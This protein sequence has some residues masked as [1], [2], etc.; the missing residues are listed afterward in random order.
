MTRTRTTRGTLLALASI[1]FAVLTA[2]GQVVPGQSGY[3]IE[4]G[5]P[6]DLHGV[7]TVFVAIVATDVE[8]ARFTQALEALD[9]TVVDDQ[10]TADVTLLLASPV[11]SVGGVPVASGS[12]TLSNGAENA[13]HITVAIIRAAGKDHGRIVY[14]R[15]FPVGGSEAPLANL[16]ER[17]RE[18]YKSANPT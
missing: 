4:P 10:D 12:S 13:P 3:T 11:T 6:S 8:R 15:R 5:E 16:L 9:L 1:L 7:K 2:G 18:I 14:T 17:F